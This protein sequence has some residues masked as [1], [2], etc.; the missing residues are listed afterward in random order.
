MLKKI[1]FFTFFAF[2]LSLNANIDDKSPQSI[3]YAEKIK[4]NKEKSKQKEEEL[5]KKSKE[6]E[7]RIK[8]KR[9][10]VDDEG[11]LRMKKYK[12]SKKLTSYPPA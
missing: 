11:F 9:R 3:E 6:K 7:D 5:R 4:Q 12:Q 10:Q 2:L 8:T 1:F